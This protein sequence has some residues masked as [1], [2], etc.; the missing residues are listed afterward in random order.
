MSRSQHFFF[1]SSPGVFAAGKMI[2]STNIFRIITKIR[3]S[4][5]YCRRDKLLL[6]QCRIL[7]LNAAWA[8][9]RRK[10]IHSVISPYLVNASLTNVGECYL[11]QSFLKSLQSTR[12]NAIINYIRKHTSNGKNKNISNS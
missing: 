5:I 3:Q 7:K 8:F 11:N 6:T 10:P 9:T 1:L 12:G 4:I 2:V